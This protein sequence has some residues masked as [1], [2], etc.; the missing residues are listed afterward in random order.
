[1]SMSFLL[2]LFDWVIAVFSVN[3][4]F[5][6]M[7]MSMSVSMAMSFVLLLNGYKRRRSKNKK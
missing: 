1:M 7:L 5:L 3:V 4:S 6:L 2:D